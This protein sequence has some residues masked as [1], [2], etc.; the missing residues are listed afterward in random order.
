MLVQY[1]ANHI[2][3]ELLRRNTLPTFARMLARLSD[4][5]LIRRDKEHHKTKVQH[6][7]S[8]AAHGFGLISILISMALVLI[9]AAALSVN[10]FKA[11]QTAEADAAASSL[12]RISFAENSYNTLFGFGYTSPANLGLANLTLPVACSNPELITGQDAALHVS[13]ATI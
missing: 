6:M 1:K 7:K 9:L 11:I 12:E 3:I 2:R 13:G 5:E 4:E 8:Q 10:I